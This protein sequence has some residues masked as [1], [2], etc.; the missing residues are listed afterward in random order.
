MA[1]EYLLNLLSHPQLLDSLDASCEEPPAERPNVHV[2]G[3][4]IQEGVMLATA[5]E[6]DGER[7]VFLPSG[8][9]RELSEGL[10]PF[11]TLGHTEAPRILSAVESG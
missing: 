3:E 7:S 10:R 2:V 6:V 4:M 5:L 1:D 8:F 11:L 9:F